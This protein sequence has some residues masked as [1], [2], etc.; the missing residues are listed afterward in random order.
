[1]GFFRRHEVP[2]DTS[3][4]VDKKEILAQKQLELGRDIMDKL[5]EVVKNRADAETDASEIGPDFFM[6]KLE[7]NA[8]KY[9][10]M[11]YVKDSAGKHFLRGFDVDLR[12]EGEELCVQPGPYKESVYFGLDQMDEFM[13]RASQEINQAQ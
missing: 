5:T 2:S 11:L 10:M 7:D 6:G 9:S 8:G 3:E 4:Q 12:N 1:M 13:D